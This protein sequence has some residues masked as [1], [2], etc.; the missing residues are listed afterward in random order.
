MIMLYSYLDSGIEVDLTRNVT[1]MNVT[2]TNDKWPKQ[3][4]VKREYI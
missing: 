1:D 3:E 2:G 4:L